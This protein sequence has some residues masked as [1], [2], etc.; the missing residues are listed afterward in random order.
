MLKVVKGTEEM[1]ALEVV[2]DF[3][4]SLHEAVK[5]AWPNVAICGCY[6]HFTQSVSRKVAA[7]GLKSA[8]Q[9]DCNVQDIVQKLSSMGF[10][11]P[12]HVI[13]AFE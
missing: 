12:H 10:L 1:N 7:L 3:E 5:S 11:P 13:G 6:F 4:I 9:K 8:Y 2:C